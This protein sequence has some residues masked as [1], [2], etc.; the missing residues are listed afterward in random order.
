[1]EKMLMFASNMFL[2]KK[3]VTCMLVH[4]EQ[5]ETSILAQEESFKHVLPK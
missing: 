1:M 3:T 5:R 2:E 4:M